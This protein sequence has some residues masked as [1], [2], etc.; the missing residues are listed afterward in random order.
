VIPT[1][2]HTL[3]A[4]T[5]ENKWIA[6]S[7]ETNNELSQSITIGATDTT[8]PDVA[9]TAPADGATVSGTTVTV[10]A[11]A[12]D[13][14][15][16]VGVQFKV[17]GENLLAEDLES[18]YEVIWNTTTFTNGL[19]TLTATARDAA[20]NS[21]SADVRTVTVNNAVPDTIPPTVSITAPE[22]GRGVPGNVTIS[23]NATERYNPKLW[24]GGMREAAYP[25]A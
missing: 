16:V 15:G 1:G 17:D 4:L 10:S 12:T 11:T 25:S 8:A 6:E 23:A 22:D 19:H 13:A 14:V 2:T 7:N 5:D 20:G 18:P 3:R 9:L 21:A 24:M